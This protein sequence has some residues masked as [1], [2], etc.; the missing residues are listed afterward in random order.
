MYTGQKKKSAFQTTFSLGMFKLTFKRL[1]E[2][3]EKKG[4]W[5][6]NCDVWQRHVLWV[7]LLQQE[8]TWHH[9]ER[10]LSGNIEETPQHFGQE[11]KAWT[12]MD[13]PSG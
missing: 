8:I 6:P 11:V 10:T 4:Q 2:I 9:E 7:F 12:Q 13:L 1:E 5:H 3:G